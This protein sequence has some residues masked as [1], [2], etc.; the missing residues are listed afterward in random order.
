[1]ASFFHPS[2]YPISPVAL[3][4]G[5]ASGFAASVVMPAA[6]QVQ[7]VEAH[8]VVTSEKASL[9]SGSGELFYK[10]SDVPAGTI[11]L[12]D[13]EVSTWSR[14]TYPSGVGVF[15]RGEDVEVQG[16]SIKVA[17]PTKLRAA[18]MGT[19]WTGSWKAALDQELPAGTPL[20]MIDAIKD[21]DTGPILGYRV[22]APEQAR[23][24]I[25]TRVIR[26]AT[27]AEIAAF[28]GRAANAGQAGNSGDSKTAAAPSTPSPTGQPAAASGAGT[29]VAA[30]PA[31]PS[32][33]APTPAPLPKAMDLTQPLT[34]V[35]DNKQNEKPSTPGSAQPVETVA[36]PGSTPNVSQPPAQPAGVPVATPAGAAAPVEVVQSSGQPV[37]DGVV[38]P[39]PSE[40]EAPAV[41]LPAPVRPAAIAYDLEATFRN[42][43]AQP[44]MSAE[45]D[46]LI[47]EYNRAIDSLDEG[48]LKQQ[49]TRR[50]DVLAI[51]RELRDK[52]RQQEE[53]RASLDADR[54]KVKQQL[55]IAEAGRVY[56][57]A[58][59][60]QVSTVYDG[61]K[62]P[63]MYRVTSIGGGSP[64]TL[65]YLRDTKE[66]DL[67]GKVG[68]IIGVIGDAQI[69]R[70]LQLNVITPVRVDVLR[71]RGAVDMLPASEGGT[72]S[73]APA[74]ITPPPVVAQ[75]APADPAPIELPDGGEVK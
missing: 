58:G 37:I 48:R 41:V 68:A 8:Y 16:T 26:K 29:P 11:L 46:E 55:A 45:V 43:M 44:V 75:P 36:I 57:I 73:A 66:M 69:D 3:V 7:S 20:K 40:A 12:V 33:T 4:A 18:N 28:K 27:E 56:T 51:R 49:L 71:P 42:V 25:E 34:A 65:G 14:V 23:A 32:A 35:I 9:R 39:A 2:G 64:R 61:S 63:L 21:G 47:A 72:N 10:I 53:A 74:N 1:M 13:G 38:T 62:L 19:G 60:L 5:L 17:A 70:S 6:G 22:V 24:Y 50:R 59:Q 54:G 15:V 52:V 30:K 67:L 31:V